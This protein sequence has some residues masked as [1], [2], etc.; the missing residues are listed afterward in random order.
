M[1]Q[2]GEVVSKKKKHTSLFQVFK[3]SNTT[4]HCTQKRMNAPANNNE[5]RA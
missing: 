2:D 1:R 5:T 4:R 3:V